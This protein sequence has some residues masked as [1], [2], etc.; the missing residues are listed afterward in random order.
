MIPVVPSRPLTEAETAVILAALTRAPVGEPDVASTYLPASLRVV[1]RCDCGCDS[2]F[3]TA[4][5]WS[6]GQH[7]V[8]E[9]VGYAAD[10]EQ[11]GIIVWA[12]D[13]GLL[14]LEVYNFE[15]SPAHLPD[16]ATVCPF[17]QAR[18]DGSGAL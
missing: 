3:F 7:R 10:G 1:G 18:S 12:G 6:E 4:S 11:I 13:Q 16:P 2:V 17:E 8:A 5:D 14:H 9:G 15:E